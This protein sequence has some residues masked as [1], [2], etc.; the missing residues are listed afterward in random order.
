MLLLLN[1]I[2]V[3]KYT[4]KVKQHL[5]YKWNVLVDDHTDTTMF[6]KQIVE[7]T[8][9]YR[10]SIHVVHYSYIKQLAIQ[11]QVMYMYN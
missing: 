8:G 9:L 10:L 6:Q 1:V 5:Y 2:H 3:S 11:F 7:C 4:K